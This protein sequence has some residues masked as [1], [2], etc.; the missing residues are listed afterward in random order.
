VRGNIETLAEL[1]DW[2]RSF[3]RGRAPE[4]A[5]EDE[6]FVREALALLPEPPYGPET[7]ATGPAR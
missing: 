4:V 2:W 3:G 7:W 5:P 6:G 1:P